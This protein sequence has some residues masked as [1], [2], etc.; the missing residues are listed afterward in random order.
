MPYK[1]VYEIEPVA[2]EV[3]TIANILDIKSRGVKDVDKVKSFIENF[4]HKTK[5]STDHL[6]MVDGIA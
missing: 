2:P 6:A 1:K 4:I 3:K 5:T